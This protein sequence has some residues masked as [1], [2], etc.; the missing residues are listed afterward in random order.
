MPPDA[1]VRTISTCRACQ[2]KGLVSIL[3]L[4]NQYVSNFVDEPLESQVS[5]PL[6]LVLCDPKAGGCGLLQL[7]YTVHMDVLYDQYWYRSG[8]NQTMRDALKDVVENAKK[9]VSLKQGDIVVDIGCNDGTLLRAYDVPGIKLVG[10]DPAKN[11]LQ[12]SSVGTDKIFVD[13][14]NAPTFEKEFGSHKAKIITS[15]AMF[16]DLDDPN[17]F[18]R[19]IQQILDEKGVWV[20]QMNH[21]WLMIR[22]NV[23][24]NICHEHLAYFSLATLEKLLQQHGLEVVDVQTNDINGGS[25]RAFI[26]HSKQAKSITVPGSKE[27]VNQIRESEKAHGLTERKTFEA[28]AQRVE[29]LKRQC[30]DFIRKENKN[31]KTIFAY[32]AS[33]KGNVMLQYYGLN[34][35]DILAAADRNPDKF[36]KKMVGGYV[37]IISEAEARARKPDYFLVLPWFFM[38]EFIPREKEFLDGGG[39]FIVPLPQFQVIDSANAAEFAARRQ[40][41]R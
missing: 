21:L 10:F 4:G 29:A 12:Y 24:D 19:D 15:I 13:F 40:L 20:I 32:G 6:E 22:D 36:G 17:A 23:F 33:T 30:V 16:Y 39:K 41:T 8:I 7:K 9:F 27:R 35:K 34:Y 11:L 37:P 5:A 3:S 2:S 14:F 25:F 31:K 38:K 28:F 26:A 18:V 1:R